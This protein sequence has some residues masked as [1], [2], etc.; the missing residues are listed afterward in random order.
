MTSNTKP[1]KLG[2]DKTHS[3]LNYWK[4]KITSYL[5]L[6]K[7]L[8]CTRKDNFQFK[9]RYFW[10]DSEDLDTV[11]KLNIFVILLHS[12]SDGFTCF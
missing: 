9:L 11:L 4:K 3:T 12:Y 6:N 7:Y 2:L 10:L 8:L 1:I 5:V